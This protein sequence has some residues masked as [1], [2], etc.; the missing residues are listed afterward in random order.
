MPPAGKQPV[1]KPED[2]NQEPDVTITRKVSEV[3]SY[4]G[5]IPPA[6]EFARYEE[7]Y[8]GSAGRLISM[9]E[10]EQQEIVSFRNKS[11]IATTIVTLTIIVAIAHI[12]TLN[13]NVLVLGALAIAQALPSITDFLRGISENAMAKKEQEL[14]I[15]I[16]KD[17]H[18]LEMEAA[19]QQLLLP[20]S[21]D[22]DSAQMLDRLESSSE[23]TDSQK[24]NL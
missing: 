11:L 10:R 20:S 24:G 9:A 19:R 6:E 14:D 16:R 4:S 13:P 7:V 22:H 23:S 3:K 12:L 1:P 17:H 8:P 2:E 21:S 15:Q 18:E 5:P